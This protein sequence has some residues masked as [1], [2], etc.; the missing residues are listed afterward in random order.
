MSGRF[1]F[2]E[3]TSEVGIEASGDSLEDVFGAVGEAVA[4]LLGAW[5]PDEGRPRAVAVEASD[6]EALLAAWVDEL[7]YLH[8]AHDVVFGG[9]DDVRVGDRRLQATV[10]AA[11]RGDREL[12]GVG[13]KAATYHRLHVAPSDEGWTARLYVDV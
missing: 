4:D 11:P 7:L 12:E 3:H 2:L 9:F 1:R 13:V 6:R 5:F 10:L 8:D